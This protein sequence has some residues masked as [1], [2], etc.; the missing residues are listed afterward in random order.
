MTIRALALT[1]GETGLEDHRLLIGAL[2][3]ATDGQ[4]PLD[5]RGGIFYAPGAADLAGEGMTARIAP[6]AAVVPGGSSPLQGAYVVVNT[7][8]VE[9]VIDDGD[10]DG[11]RTDV[12]GVVVNDDRFDESGNTD[13][14]VRVIDEAVDASFIPLHAVDIPQGASAGTGGIPW[15]SA[16]Q[17]MRT[18]TA[19]AGG[20]V[21]VPDLA[22]RARLDSVPE[23][24][25]VHVN[26]VGDLYQRN[27]GDWRGVVGA[28]ARRALLQELDERYLGRPG[29]WRRVEMTEGVTHK[30]DDPVEMRATPQ[31]LVFMRGTFVVDDDREVN[32]SK[33]AR[34]P[35]GFEP[36]ALVR[37]STASGQNRDAGFNSSRLEVRSDGDIYAYNLY[38]TGWISADNLVYWAS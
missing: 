12:I 11:T 37:W 34:A 1:S 14:A 8:T 21:A 26:S 6:F 9:V 31:G 2:L 30:P 5:R 35:S 19:T 15:G 4:W 27:G 36:P 16:V 33:I 7:D 23:G 18:Y 3:G 10:G 20:V 24:M 32:A 17:D 28:E 25:L 38:D 22:A 13:A 29:E